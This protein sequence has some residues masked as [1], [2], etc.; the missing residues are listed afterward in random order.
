MTSLDGNFVESVRL[1]KAEKKEMRVLDREEQFRLIAA[2]RLA[3]AGLATV[4]KDDHGVVIQVASPLQIKI[5]KTASDKHQK[6]IW[7]IMSNKSL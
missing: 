3:S 2:A 6:P 4:S 1:P 5:R 7:N